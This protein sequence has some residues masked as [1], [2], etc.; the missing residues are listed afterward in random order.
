MLP[1]QILA[2]ANNQMLTIMGVF[3]INELARSL[4]NHNLHIQ[5]AI[6]LILKSPYVNIR[7]YVVNVPYSFVIYPMF[8]TPDARLEMSLALKNEIYVF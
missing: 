7:F 8:D 6:I 5:T 3:T 4:D 2:L 1:H